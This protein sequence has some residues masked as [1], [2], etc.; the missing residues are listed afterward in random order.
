MSLHAQLS[1]PLLIC[2]KP[3]R[4]SSAALV[5]ALLSALDERCGGRACAHPVAALAG[6]AHI[7]ASQPRPLSSRQSSLRSACCFVSVSTLSPSTL[8]SHAYMQPRASSC[9]GL[10]PRPRRRSCACPV[11]KPTPL[12]SP[13]VAA[14]AAAAA[15]HQE[16]ADGPS[17]HLPAPHLNVCCPA[18]AKASARSTLPSSA[19]PTLALWRC[20]LLQPL[21]EQLALPRLE[22]QCRSE[23]PLL[24]H[25]H[26]AL[27]RF[28]ALLVAPSHGLGKRGG[29]VVQLVAEALE[30]GLQPADSRRGG[31]GGGGGA[32]A[33]A[34]PR[35]RLDRC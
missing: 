31:R 14:A 5:P 20:R 35:L 17:P 28:V 12:R 2:P 24:A 9:P 16:P 19:A 29:E 18:W 27:D 8:I 21:D 10:P 11:P 30:D 34:R 23:L 32:A 25:L 15:S 1:T 3:V 22:W 6:A 7:H 26:E 13:A 33:A 4:H